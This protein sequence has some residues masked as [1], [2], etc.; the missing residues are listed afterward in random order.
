MLP[1]FV[2][3][4]MPA[5]P[6]NVTSIKISHYSIMILSVTLRYHYGYIKLLV[7]NSPSPRLRRGSLFIVWRWSMRPSGR[8]LHL[9]TI[10]NLLL[11]AFQASIHHGGRGRTLPVQY[12]LTNRQQ[13]GLMYV[14]VR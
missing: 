8:M 13:P 10:R 2:S 3:I 1:Y 7:T 5:W 4:N 11:P 12:L 9:H 14:D 6:K